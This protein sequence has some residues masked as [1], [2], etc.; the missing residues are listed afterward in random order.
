MVGNENK[1]KRKFFQ[2]QHVKTYILINY[3]NDVCHQYFKN[4]ITM[5]GWGNI[6]YSKS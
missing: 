6:H 4:H 2:L 1:G 5:I 3:I